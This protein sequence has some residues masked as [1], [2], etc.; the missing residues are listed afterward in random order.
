MYIS[1]SSVASPGKVS[2]PSAADFANYVVAEISA[3]WKHVAIQLGLST[4]K[5]NEIKKNEDECRDRFMAVFDEWE[6]GSCKPFTWSTLI[7]ALKSPIV[8]KYELA[9]KLQQKFYS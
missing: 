9:E 1:S 5:C 6:R 4:N 2:V 3:E 7:T 8:G